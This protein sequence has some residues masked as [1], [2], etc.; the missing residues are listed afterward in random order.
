[1]RD[2]SRT[3]APEKKAPWKF[4]Q[5]RIA[6]IRNFLTYSANLASFQQKKPTQHNLSNSRINVLIVII[7]GMH[8]L[9]MIGHQKEMGLSFIFSL[10]SQFSAKK[11]NTAQ[12]VQLPKKCAG[13]NEKKVLSTL[14][15]LPLETDGSFYIFRH[16]SYFSAKN[17]FLRI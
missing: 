15:D 16:F 9:C 12:F 4:A 14:Y 5:I 8:Q 1:M 10:F 13:S 11:A 3:I 2:G 6:K 7:K 17:F